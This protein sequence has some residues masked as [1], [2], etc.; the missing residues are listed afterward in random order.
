VFVANGSS[1]AVVTGLVIGVI[2]AAQAVGWGADGEI[3]DGVDDTPGAQSAPETDDGESP[4]REHPTSVEGGLAGPPSAVQTDGTITSTGRRGRTIALTFS[5]GPD[6]WS[7]PRVLDILDKH[8]VDATFCVLGTVAREQPELIR[9]IASEGHALCDQGLLLDFGL[10]TR[11]DERIKQE[12]GLTLDAIVAAAPAATVPFFRAPGG[13]FSPR[14][15]DIAASYGQVPLGWSIE[16]ADAPGPGTRAII[17]SVMDRV[18]SGAVMLLRD[19][20]GEDRPDTVA[21]LDDLIEQLD[22]AGYEFV[23]PAP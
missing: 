10:A 15:N 6:P 17:D 2:L 20:G 3:G 7:T 19:G 5:T 21:A 14:L 4:E 11:G 18:E 9:R 12:I 8:G 13:G 1:G 23:I 22:A 16:I